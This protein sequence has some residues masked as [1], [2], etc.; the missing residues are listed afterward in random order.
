MSTDVIASQPTGRLPDRAKPA[1]AMLTAP[2]LPTLVRLSLPNMMAMLDG[3]VTWARPINANMPVRCAPRP[4]S[5][6]VST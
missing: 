3:A 1:D 4:N 2:I 6:N 5:P